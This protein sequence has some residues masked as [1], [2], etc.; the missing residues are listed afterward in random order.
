MPNFSAIFQTGLTIS[1]C[2]VMPNCSVISWQEQVA[3]D[4]MIM[5]P[6]CTRQR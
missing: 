1:D 2:C 6:L 3:V 5:M 4:V